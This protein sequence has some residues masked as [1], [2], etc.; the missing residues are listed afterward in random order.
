V[1]WKVKRKKRNEGDL[2][3]G[4]VKVI[5]KK[6]WQQTEVGTVTGQIVTALNAQSA[7][8]VSMD[9]VGYVE[10]R[11]TAE[12]AGFTYDKFTNLKTALDTWKNANGV[13]VSLLSWEE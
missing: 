10:L 2:K 3:M 6:N 12:G 11:V 5:A 8:I 9:W 13:N 4:S 1:L 7:N